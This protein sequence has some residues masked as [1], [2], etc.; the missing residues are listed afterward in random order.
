MEQA[1]FVESTTQY[2]SPLSYSLPAPKYLILSYIADDILRD[3][4]LDLLYYFETLEAVR[5]QET[6][7]GV[8]VK[9][10]GKIFANL[11][12]KRHHF[13]LG[14]FQRGNWVAKHVHS[15]HT[16]ET[17]KN[18]FDDS[19][20]ETNSW[21]IILGIG[22]ENIKRTEEAVESESKKRGRPRKW[23]PKTNG[24]FVHRMDDGKPI[25]DGIPLAMKRGMIT[26]FR[27][28]QE[29]IPVAQRVEWI[30]ELYMVTYQQTHHVLKDEL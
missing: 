5:I 22:T 23:F 1:V 27:K 18:Y 9:T 17:L 30:A 8:S 26:D 13:V 7:S 2:A 6:K 15:E 28:L 3:L 4:A 19:P 25:D 20:V 11:W 29:D 12:P 24:R 16:L 14:F 21:N 10:H